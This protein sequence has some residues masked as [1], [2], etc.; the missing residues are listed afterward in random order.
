MKKLLPLIL[1]LI[2]SCEDIGLIDEGKRAL[3]ELCFALSIVNQ[4]NGEKDGW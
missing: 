2:F 4:G 3:D 1:L